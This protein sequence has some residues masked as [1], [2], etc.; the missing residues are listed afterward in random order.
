LTTIEARYPSE[1]EQRCS[2]PGIGH[3]TAAYLLLFAGGFTSFQNHRQ[4][5]AKAGLCP[6]EF[7]SGT[8]V[9]GKARISTMGGAVIRSKLFRC[10]WSARQ[11]SGACRALYDRLVA[12]EAGPD[13][14]LQQAPQ[15]GLCHRGLRS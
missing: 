7:N 8:R 14:R 13:C 12:K 10:S 9:R 1:K 2:I 11:A 3:K 15:A 6:R 5:I 4:L